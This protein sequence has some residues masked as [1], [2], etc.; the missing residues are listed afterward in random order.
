MKILFIISSLFKGGSEQNLLELAYSLNKNKN[1]DSE[2]L[3]LGKGDINLF[4][5]K[6][7][8]LNIKFLNKKIKINH[9][10]S[11]LRPR[12]NKKYKCFDYIHACDLLSLEYAIINF[13][14]SDIKI[15]AGC[16]H[17]NEYIW[18]DGS[19]YRKASIKRQ[20]SIPINN[21][22]FGNLE[23]YNLNKPY[24]KTAENQDVAP[25]NIFNI[26]IKVFSESIELNVNKIILLSGRL[27]SFKSYLFHIA[28]FW[29]SNWKR[30]PE[31]NLHIVGEGAAEKK[32]KKILEDADNYKFFGMQSIE[33]LERK[34]KSS[35]VSIASGTTYLRSSLLTYSIIG[36]ENDEKGIVPTDHKEYKNSYATSSYKNFTL[37][38]DEI[39][40]S[41]MMNAADRNKCIEKNVKKLHRLDWNTY[42]KNFEVFLERSNDI[43]NIL[44]F[45]I[46]DRMMF[47]YLLIHAVIF[48][49][50]SKFRNRFSINWT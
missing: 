37:L 43:N 15:T 41:L 39:H 16:Y 36:L 44:K 8:E 21:I 42:I 7:R 28:K 1:F 9:Y 30:Y 14:S 27:D 22:Y 4:S 18:D 33:Q 50:K 11:I 34:M 32:L 26:G 2:I 31:Y 6:Y 46:I 23:M 45:S 17:Q 40:K 10:F 47:F 12:L 25:S 38:E 24:F 3:I 29:R 20:R 35:W 48:P 5:K 19:R 49:K 13:S